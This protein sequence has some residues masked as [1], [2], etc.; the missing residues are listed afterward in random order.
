MIHSS[1]GAGTRTRPPTSGTFHN[2]GRVAHS[3]WVRKIIKYNWD[4]LTWRQALRGR[5]VEQTDAGKRRETQRAQAFRAS[6]NRLYMGGDLAR[7]ARLLME[8]V[9]GP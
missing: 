8:R 7:A 9:H 4:Q 3:K 5:P 1:P 2:L 6:A